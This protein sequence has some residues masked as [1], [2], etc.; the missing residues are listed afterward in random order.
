MD[1]TVIGFILKLS[2]AKFHWISFLHNTNYATILN[3][4]VQI[5]HFQMIYFYSFITARSF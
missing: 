2:F 5:N 1:F 4:S 3:L